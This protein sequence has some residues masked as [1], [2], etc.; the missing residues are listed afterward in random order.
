MEYTGTQ[1][2]TVEH[3]TAGGVIEVTIDFDKNF[4]IHPENEKEY[5]AIEMIKEMVEFWAYWEAELKDWNGDYVKC[6]LVSLAKE[7]FRVG[8]YND[9]NCYGITEH[10]AE[11]EGWS[12][13]DGSC[14]IMITDFENIEITNDDLSIRID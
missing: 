10:F 4:K 3:D 14:G 2:F 1:K 6:F 5:T 12:N 8:L 11:A 7:C 9:W 13:M